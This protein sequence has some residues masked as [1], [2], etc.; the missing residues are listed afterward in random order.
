MQLVTKTVNRSGVKVRFACVHGRQR[1]VPVL[2]S[3]VLFFVA[4]TTG[5]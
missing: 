4:V 3:A 5:V 2:V 1:L